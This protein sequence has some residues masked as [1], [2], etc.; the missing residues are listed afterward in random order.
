MIQQL[1]ILSVGNRIEHSDLPDSLVASVPI[2][3]SDSWQ[4]QLA[5]EVSHKLRLGEKA[6]AR[7]LGR[8]FEQVLIGAA[9]EHTRGH[10]QQAAELL[11]WGRNT[12]TRK[13]GRR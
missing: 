4:R 1:S 12:L 13:M 3:S 7:T 10:K 8:E 11:G 5:G 6:L 9:L 2:E